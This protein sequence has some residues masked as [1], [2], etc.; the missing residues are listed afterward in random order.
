MRTTTMAPYAFVA[1][2]LLKYGQEFFFRKKKCWMEING[3]GCDAWTTICHVKRIAVVIFS[4]SPLLSFQNYLEIVYSFRFIATFFVCVCVYVAPFHF[5]SI[6][7][8]M[9]CIHVLALLIL[10]LK[11]TMISVKCISLKKYRHNVVWIRD[12]RLIWTHDCFDYE[13]YDETQSTRQNE[14][15]WMNEW[16]PF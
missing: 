10:N 7:S 12:K 9:W 8:R 5:D 4:Y 13:D 1:E 3:L 6:V 2:D 16:Q 14:R 15:R 11:D